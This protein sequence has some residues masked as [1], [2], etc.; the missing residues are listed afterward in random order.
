M[1]IGIQETPGPALHIG[2]WHADPRTNELTRNGETI[3]VEPKAMEV[4]VFL[5]ERAGQVVSREALLAALW[6]G[7]VVGDDTLTQAVIKLRKSLRD[8]ARSPQYIETISKRGY[9]L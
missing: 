6:S 7:T 8:E 5:A 2:D 1:A 9:R 4:L 3:R